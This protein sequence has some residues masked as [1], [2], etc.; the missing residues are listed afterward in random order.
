[1]HLLLSFSTMALSGAPYMA[2]YPPRMIKTALASRAVPLHEAARDSPT[3]G[4]LMDLSRESASRLES[5]RHLIPLALHSAL[6]AGPIDAGA[7]CLLVS[8][9]AAAAKTRQL[10]PLLLT[11]LQ[12]Q[13][14]DITSIR[15]KILAR[16]AEKI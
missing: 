14:A 4:R 8:N 13:G 1:M 11:A 7:W 16:R 12:R 5:V 2:S 15:V 3:L 9:N 10:L 6:Q